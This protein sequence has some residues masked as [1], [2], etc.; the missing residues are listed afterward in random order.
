[1]HEATGGRSSLGAAALAVSVLALIVALTGVAVGLPGKKQIDKNDL[2]KNVVR[3][4][5]VAPN[6]LNGTDIAE[7][8]LGQVASAASADAPAVYARVDDGPGPTAGVDET[9]SKGITDA[10]VADPGAGGGVVCFDL[11]FTP[12]GGNAGPD[13]GITG[14]GDWVTQLGL[15]DPNFDCDPPFEDAVTFSAID[16]TAGDVSFFVAFY[17]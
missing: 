8:S 5:N 12:K 14:G 10:M 1:M 3:S 4:K 6:A 16:G 17:R 2:R 15:G 9:L 13:Y 11:P 7:A